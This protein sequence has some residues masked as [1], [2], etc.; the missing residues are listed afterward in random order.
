MFRDILVLVD[1]SRFAEAAVPLASRLARLAGARLHLV[2]AHELSAIVVGGG[3]IVPAPSDLYEELKAQGT[4]YLSGTA[5]KLRPGPDGPAEFH[6][7]EGPVGPA[8]CEEAT[9]LDAD[10][11]VM[12]THGRGAF[13]RFWL[14][15]VADYVIRHLSTPVL[16]VHPGNGK[17]PAQ[18]HALRGILVALDLS[19]DSE[20]ILEPVTELAR[21]TG[22]ALTLIHVA[23]LTFEIGR[24]AMPAPILSD[25]ELLEASRVEALDRLD[26]IA[27]RLRKLHLNVTTRVV[28]GAAAS[29]GLLNA[30]EENRFDMIALTTRGAAGVRR[31]LLGS[32]ADKVIRGANKPVLVLHPQTAVA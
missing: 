10:L 7:V 25:A 20:A 8:I 11:V 5:A 23:E 17:A 26:R 18:G 21:M 6:Q 12:A 3:E 13:G 32:V 29:S 2:L 1:G 4:S 28:S 22:A 16:L 15:S 24:M 14:G 19:K 27:A 31:L 9:R 30:L